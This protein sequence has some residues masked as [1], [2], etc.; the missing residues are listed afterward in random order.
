MYMQDKWELFDFNIAAELYKLRRNIPSAIQPR[1]SKS[2]LQTYYE[3]YSKYYF[4]HDVKK[5][6]YK[7]TEHYVMP[8]LSGVTQVFY[9]DYVF[10]GEYLKAVHPYYKKEH[11]I[12]YKD[13]VYKKYRHPCI[14]EEDYAYSLD[15]ESTPKKVL[16]EAD[17]LIVDDKGTVR[18]LD[19][20]QQKMF[21]KV[22]TR[23]IGTI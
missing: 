4:K 6:F 7:K 12:F 5:L 8:T 11:T 22:D 13:Y 10:K 15:N 16:V 17:F 1:L 20:E 2:I 9:H 14:I 23:Y 19:S 3:D 18:K 21:S